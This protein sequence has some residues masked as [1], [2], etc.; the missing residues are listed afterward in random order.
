MWHF[1]EPLN[2]HTIAYAHWLSSNDDV[3]K[4]LVAVDLKTTNFY[5]FINT[6][7]LISLTIL[8]E[9]ESLK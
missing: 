2:P 8:F 7:V 6:N 9:N 4:T 5:D 3:F 1:N